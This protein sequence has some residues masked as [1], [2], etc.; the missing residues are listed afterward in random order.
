MMTDDLVG[1]TT[2]LIDQL[3]TKTLTLETYNLFYRTKKA[4]DL[5]LETKFN[6]VGGDK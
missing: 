4:A 5:N 3:C 1:E 2:L 6:P